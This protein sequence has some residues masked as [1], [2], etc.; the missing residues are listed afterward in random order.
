MGSV[1][2]RNPF[3]SQNQHKEHAWATNESVRF[4]LLKQPVACSV[5]RA[6][7][8][9]AAHE[10][11]HPEREASIILNFASEVRIYSRS[12]SFATTAAVSRRLTPASR[13]GRRPLVGRHSGAFRANRVCVGKSCRFFISQRLGSVATRIQQ[14]QAHSF[15]A[16]TG[17]LGGS[18]RPGCAFSIEDRFWLFAPRVL[19]SL[20]LLVSSFF[21]SLFYVLD[22]FPREVLFK[23]QNSG[24]TWPGSSSRSD[25]MWL[26][27]VPVQT[28][29]IFCPKRSSA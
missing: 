26:L 4:D 24:S 17:L 15:T 11:S 8:G 20:F 23:T 25:E 5:S 16:S 10:T 12:C 19:C 28:D 7:I 18:F 6:P 22:L 9:A 3:S 13:P 27:L 29:F 2:D 1:K 21:P 14:E